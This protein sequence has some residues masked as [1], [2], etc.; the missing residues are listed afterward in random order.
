V[1]VITLPVDSRFVFTS[2]PTV[3]KA[4]E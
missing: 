3:L 2:I 4:G 1:I